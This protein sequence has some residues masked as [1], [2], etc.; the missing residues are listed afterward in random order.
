MTPEETCRSYAKANVKMFLFTYNELAATA[1]FTHAECI[2][3]ATDLVAASI[4]Q[5]GNYCE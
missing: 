3:I 2:Q 1:R 5:A 4:K